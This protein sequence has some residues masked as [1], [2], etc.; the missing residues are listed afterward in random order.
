MP[1]PHVNKSENRK[2]VDTSNPYVQILLNTDF[3]TEET[4]A[5]TGLENIPEYQVLVALNS[6]DNMTQEQLQQSVDHP[7]VAAAVKNLLGAE[8]LIEQSDTYQLSDSVKSKL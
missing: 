1:K 6:Q 3:V 8:L 7:L 5:T 2:E 4:L